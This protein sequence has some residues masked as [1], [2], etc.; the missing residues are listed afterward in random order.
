MELA[1]PSIDE[2]IRACVA[3]GATRLLVVP[4]MLAPG[5]H[6]VKDIPRLVRTALESY[7][8]VDAVVSGPLGV[9]PGLADVVLA[10]IEECGVRPGGSDA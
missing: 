4:Y 10:R 2:G 6:A 3:S 9:H 5:R 7:P 1:P 8:G